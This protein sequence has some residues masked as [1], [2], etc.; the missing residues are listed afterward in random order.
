MRSKRTYISLVGA[1]IVVLL[2]VAC[3]DTKFYAEV[4]AGPKQCKSG[5]TRCE[6]NAWEVCEN[7]RW[8]SQPCGD[9][10]VCVEEIGCRLCQ[11]D[12]EFCEGQDTFQCSPDGTA[13]Q[14]TGTCLPEQQC[15]LGMCLD[16]CDLPTRD[17]SNVGCEFWAVDLPNEYFC[18][19]YDGGITCGA[20]PFG[21][22]CAACQ[23]FAVAVA[24]TSRFKVMVMVEINDAAPGEPLSL[25]LL[26]RREIEPE[27][28]EVFNL[29]MR[30]VDCTTWAFDVTGNLRRTSDSQSCLSSRAFRIKSTYPV[31][32]Y[33]FN[34]IVNDFSNGASLLIPTNGLDDEYMV[35]GWPTTNPIN[36]M[37]GMAPE[38]VPDYS[39][40]T[41]VG[42]EAGTTVDVTLAHPTQ[43]TADGKIPAGKIGDT[44]TVELG[45]FDVLNLNTFQDLEHFSGDLTGSAVKANKPVV[46]FSGGQRAS[47]PSDLDQYSPKPPVPG[48]EYEICCTEHFEQQMFPVSA[49]GK[50]FAITRTP[51]R[52]RIAHEP[53]L[54]RILAT[55]DG[56]TVKTNLGDFP[57][58]QL[59]KGEMANF[60]STV[61][62]VIDS[63]QP[64]MI[65]QIAVAQG[66]LK[67]YTGPGGD[68]EFVVFPPYEQF[69]KDYI[70]LTPG[71][72]DKDFVVIATPAG[73]II[74]LDGDDIT[75]EFND[76]CI[77]DSIGKIDGEEYLGY[78]C[79]VEDGVHKVNSTLPVGI[80]V[81]GY[82]NVGSYGYPGGADI[83]KINIVE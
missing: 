70:F 3:A 48:E 64:I 38:G 7:E 76:R 60:W 57:L 11:P 59:D 28:L 41:I 52:Q 39:Y 27:S 14:Q 6:E 71:T 37:P 80:M 65:A 66:F 79:E 54:Y 5:E 17:R 63:D 13:S 78:H 20:P 53:D 62:F 19:S 25:G 1:S 46:V 33:Q 32:A 72:F 83:K 24:N 58:F 12:S 69:R 55:R 9:D 10:N 2:A 40:V 50:A 42:V 31:V 26:D 68:P 82:Y 47:A 74:E 49:L 15:A 36:V 23:Q 29:P 34:P 73:A 77:R 18:Q 8:A 44:I 21:Y 4:D 22:G 75:G 30:E 61:N 16:L 45:P 43:G 67:D 51:Q 56:T 35:M 81:Y